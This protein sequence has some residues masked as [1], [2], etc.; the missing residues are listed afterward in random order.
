MKLD[1]TLKQFNNTKDKSKAIILKINK[2]GKSVN[3]HVRK[4]QIINI[5]NE[6]GNT[7]IDPKGINSTVSTYYKQFHVNKLN[8]INTIGKLLERFNSKY[9]ILKFQNEQLQISQKLIN[10]LSIEKCPGLD[11]FTDEFCQ[12]FKKER[13]PIIHRLRTQKN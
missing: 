11:S 13:I 9:N 10:N 4:T 1:E 3:R 6:R 5:N 7:S 12:P 8:N 2:I